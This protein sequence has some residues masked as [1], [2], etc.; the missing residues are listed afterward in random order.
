MVQTWRRDAVLTAIADAA[1]G[2]V[3]PANLK[4]Q[5]GAEKVPSG[6]AMTGDELLSMNWFVEGVEGT[7]PQ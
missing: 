1:Q 3:V 5:A 6:T 4:D 7:I 2:G